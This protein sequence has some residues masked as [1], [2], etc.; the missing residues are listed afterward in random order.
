MRAGA[1]CAVATISILLMTAGPAAAEL[2]RDDG[3]EPGSS[4][5]T[6]KAVL[7]F[8]VVPVGIAVA[9]ALLVSL[10]SIVKGPRYRPGAGWTGQPEWLGAPTTDAA[11][12][13][14]GR[15]GGA[16]GETDLERA[17][18]ADAAELTGTIVR[19]GGEAEP[20]PGDGGTS[21]RW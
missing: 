8:G 16:Y 5:S 13:L 17:R 9:I 1:V 7:I 4:M 21:A 6:L 10:P 3:D 12:A 18:A 2:H 20:E 15:T 14:E 19:S 11:P